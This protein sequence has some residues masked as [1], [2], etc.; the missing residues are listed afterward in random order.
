MK[1][2]A[3]GAACSVIVVLAACG[4]DDSNTSPGGAGAS[5]K[6]G[7]AAGTG[8]SA[9]TGR[10]PWGECPGSSGGAGGEQTCTGEAEYDACVTSKCDAK[11][12]E[13]FGDGYASGTYGGTCGP[14][15]QCV[16]GC[17]CGDTACEMSCMLQASEACKTCSDEFDACV[18]GS[19]CPEPQCGAGGAGGTAGEA[20]AAGGEQ[21][22]SAGAAPSCPYTTDSL[23]CTTSCA[24]LKDIAAKCQN[25]PNLSAELK[26][27]LQTAAQGT[28]TACK[29]ACA[30]DSAAYRNLWKCFQAVPVSADCTAIAGCTKVN[31]P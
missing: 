12:K 25:D 13:C 24:N 14:V 19:G 29:A 3:L 11:A 22:G 26:T 7:A 5:G 23:D 10:N 8:G 2:I 17:K 15:I 6:G 16:V 9:G 21:G 30:S 1:A 18:S 27:L 20:G 31:C 4:S 28:G